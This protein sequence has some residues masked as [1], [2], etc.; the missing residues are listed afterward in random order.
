MRGDGGEELRGEVE[1]LHRAFCLFVL[2]RKV[3]VWWVCGIGATKFRWM[4]SEQEG[5]AVTEEEVVA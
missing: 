3:E 2:F 1:E 4:K 5:F